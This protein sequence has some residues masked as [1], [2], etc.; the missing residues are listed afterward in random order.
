MKFGYWA[1]R[2][3]DDAAEPSPMLGAA[4]PE[5]AAAA[6]AQRLIEQD[7]GDWLAGPIRVWDAKT[8]IEGAI[9]FDVTASFVESE[10]E[11]GEYDCELEIVERE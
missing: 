6:L 8:G 9:I 2:A 5:D 10:D 4:S 3:D 1:Q 7:E 11:E